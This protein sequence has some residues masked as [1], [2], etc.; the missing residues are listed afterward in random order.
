MHENTWQREALF[1]NLLFCKLDK[2]DGHLFTR[3]GDVY[4]GELIF[5]M[6]IG[7]NNLGGGH[8]RRGKSRAYMRG[9]GI[10]AKSSLSLLLSL[11]LIYFTTF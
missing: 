11:L 6:F 9:D 1:V 2:F 10:Y 3:R 8:I 5:G 7:L 4:T